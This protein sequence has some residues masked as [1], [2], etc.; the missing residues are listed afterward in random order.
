[1]TS[2]QA[3]NS[4]PTFTS[5]NNVPK[6]QYTGTVIGGAA[7]ATFGTFAMCSPLNKGTRVM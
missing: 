5:N 6:K 2:V 4:S 3:I 7:A 1:M